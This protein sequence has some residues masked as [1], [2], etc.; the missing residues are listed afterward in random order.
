MSD[1]WLAN[2]WTNSKYGGG[3]RHVGGGRGRM[4]MVDKRTRDRGR[5]IERGNVGKRLRRWVRD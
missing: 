4:S 1:V 2:G 5:R 3:R